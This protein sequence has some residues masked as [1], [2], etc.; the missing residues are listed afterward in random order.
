MAEPARVRSPR[1][2]PTSVPPPRGDR[3]RVVDEV[4]CR[5]SPP[6]VG[7]ASGGIVPESSHNTLPGGRQP[8]DGRAEQRWRRTAVDP[9]ARRRHRRTGR[10][11]AASRSR[12]A[13][14]RDR[15]P[16][17]RAWIGRLF[18]QPYGNAEPPRVARR[19]SAS[20]RGGV[21]RP[22]RRRSPRASDRTARSRRAGSGRTP[23]R[24]AGAPTPTSAT[25][26]PA[27]T[28]PGECPGLV[29]M[30]ERAGD[31]GVHRAHPARV[32][33]TMSSIGMIESHGKPP[34]RACSRMS[35]GSEV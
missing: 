10:P 17:R 4:R 27:R 31:Q 34:R 30:R 5:E 21:P 28:G 13:A 8:L 22:R 9:G 25:R 20:V 16:S 18:A 3:R 15:P 33:S 1:H 14:S 12:L 6:A 32:G 26:A 29:R 23:C 19:P 2:E 7:G 11:A 35:S 24:P